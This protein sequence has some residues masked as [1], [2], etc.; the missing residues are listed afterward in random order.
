[1][2]LK[3]S[4][5][6]TIIQAV[7]IIIAGLIAITHY[8]FQHQRRQS[9]IAL[10]LETYKLLPVMIVFFLLS[11]ISFLTPI[12][13]EGAKL[14]DA[15]VK[16]L[17]INIVALIA[18]FVEIKI[19]AKYANEKI[20]N[21]L[22]IILFFVLLYFDLKLMI[23]HINEIS[24]FV[25]ALGC[26]TLLC[27]FVSACVNLYSLF[28]NDM[29]GANMLFKLQ[30]GE[31]FSAELLSETKQ[32]DFIVKKASEPNTEYWINRDQVIHIVKEVPRVRS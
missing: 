25:I 31:E 5:I 15:S 8:C 21:V 12:F 20:K 27:Y 2:E 16:I 19:L 3:L 26:F 13:I 28:F 14:S 7:A 18:A 1:M 23:P 10:I 9:K 24:F 30:N 29:K 11:L 4:D 32:G 17:I 22:Y 6:L